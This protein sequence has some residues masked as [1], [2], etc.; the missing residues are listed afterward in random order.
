[1]FLKYLFS[2]E[3]RRNLWLDWIPEGPLLDY[4]NVPFPDRGTDWRAVDYLALDFETTGFDAKSDEIVSMGFALLRGERLVLEEN[5][6]YLV[7]SGRPMPE[8]SAIVHG[9]MDD[10]MASGVRIEQALPPLLQALAGRVMVAHH[11][12]IEYFFLNEACKRVYGCPF[13]GPVVDTLTLE[14]RAYR[15]RDKTPKSG[16]LRLP[17]V[18]S[19]YNLPRY[20]AHNALIDA[21]AAGEL[22]LAQVAHRVGRGVIKLNDLT[23]LT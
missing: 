7:R 5:R 13:I 12:N 1:M 23:V 8:A 4:Y 11:S 18:R 15:R 14:V 20:R 17:N 3:E 9:I 22:F 19:R 2:L 10:E 21:I 16:E 6:H